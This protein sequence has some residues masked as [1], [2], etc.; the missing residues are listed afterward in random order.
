MRRAACALVAIFQAVVCRCV[1]PSA[2]PDRE[3]GFPLAWRGILLLG[4]WSALTGAFAKPVHQYSWCT[5][6]LH[7]PVGLALPRLQTPG[8]AGH[9]LHLGTTQTKF[10]H[11]RHKSGL[12]TR[13]HGKC[14]ER[15]RCE[16]FYPCIVSG[17]G[18]CRTGVS[19]AVAIS[20]LVNPPH[21]SHKHRHSR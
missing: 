19:L 3:S 8:Q 10:F 9:T 14:F 12:K 1:F 6:S 21:S 20:A 13:M 15:S 4:V 2:F 17:G 18:A 7:V 5:T 11:G 16:P